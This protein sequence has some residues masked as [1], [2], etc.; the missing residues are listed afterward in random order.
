ML[1][2]YVH[3][4][5]CPTAADVDRWGGG[6]V[7]FALDLDNALQAISSGALRVN[8]QT[9]PRLDNVVLYVDYAS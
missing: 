1:M 7:A 9:G 6:L 3:V 5:P 4:Q 8:I 2:H